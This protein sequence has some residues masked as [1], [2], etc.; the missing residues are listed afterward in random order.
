MEASKED[1]Q[2]N[3]KVE[4]SITTSR[5]RTLSEKSNITSTIEKT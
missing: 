3:P 4:E 1:L 5:D 2:C